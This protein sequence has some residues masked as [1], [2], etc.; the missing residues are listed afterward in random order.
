MKDSKVM[1]IGEFCNEISLVIQAYFKTS[2]PTFTDVAD[3][4]SFVFGAISNIMS[5]TYFSF[6]TYGEKQ[7]MIH[8]H[9][10]P[11]A[12]KPDA[13]LP[14]SVDNTLLRFPMF[15]VRRKRHEP[16]GKLLPYEVVAVD[17]HGK[18]MKKEELGRTF[19]SYLM[20]QAMRVYA[21]ALSAMLEPALDFEE[22][23]LTYRKAG[24]TTLSEVHAVFR[25]AAYFT[26]QWNANFSMTMSPDMACG[27][28]CRGANPFM[29]DMCDIP[30]VMQDE[31]LTR[32]I[33]TLDTAGWIEHL[34]PAVFKKIHYI[35]PQ[36][37]G[38][39][40]KSMYSIISV[41]KW[42]RVAPM[43]DALAAY[44][45]WTA[46]MEDLFVKVAFL[47]LHPTT[48]HNMGMTEEDAVP[49]EQVRSITN[50]GQWYAYSYA[51]GTIT[52]GKFTSGADIP[53]LSNNLIYVI[54]DERV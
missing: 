33:H 39:F 53:A 15:R 16:S 9:V 52:R 32:V 46:Y 49:E 6:N 37:G 30:V 10:T 4:E 35:R 29:C 18:L 40:Q 3:V 45:C 51:T 31:V 36:L 23:I 50:S 22:T 20:T 24:I 25:K 21:Q 41:F 47:M 38:P 43:Y 12:E 13:F 19:Q 1:L 34:T 27:I 54:P 8:L 44:P 14:F 26:A 28:A 11:S 7:S 5:G 42:R 2:T 17:R 48:T